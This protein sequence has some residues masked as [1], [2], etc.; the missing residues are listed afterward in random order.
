M[1]RFIAYLGDPILLDD[2]FFKPK[3]SLIKQSYDAKELDEPLNGDGFGVGWYAQESSPNPAVFVSTTPAWSNRNLKSMAKLVKS[4]CVFGHV[5]AA[6][7]GD[8]NEANCHPFTF[9]NWIF[10][11]NGN[12]DDFTSIKRPMQK[13]LSDVAYHSVKGQTDSEHFFSLFLDQIKIKKDASIDEVVTGMGRAF[14]QL[15]TLKAS[16]GCEEPSYLNTCVSNGK[17]VVATRYCSHPDYD[18]PSLYYATGTKYVCENGIC[19]MVE[20]EPGKCSAMVVSERLTE[21]SSDWEKVPRD[22]FVIVYP[23]LRVEIKPIV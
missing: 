9:E 13:L 8:T 1:C 10:M 20:A 7:T 2:L 22:H 4:S 16:L 19:R 23:N 18:P 6:T 17:F 5:R 3:N 12:I 21:L 15:A 11:H 14:K